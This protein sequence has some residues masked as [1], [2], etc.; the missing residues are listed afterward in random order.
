MEEQASQ[1]VEDRPSSSVD[2]QETDVEQPQEEWVG[3]D[4]DED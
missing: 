2:E 1:P 4:A 3:D